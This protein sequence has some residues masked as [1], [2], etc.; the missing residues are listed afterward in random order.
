ML[1]ADPLVD[2]LLGY[3]LKRPPDCG[4]GESPRK[5]ERR[6]TSCGGV[7][8]DVDCVRLGGRLLE[9]GEAAGGVEWSTKP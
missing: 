8:D 4:T 9:E 6:L 1:A 3:G 7:G 5:G 2:T